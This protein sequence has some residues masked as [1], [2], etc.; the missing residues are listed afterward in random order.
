LTY[1]L[2]K[3]SEPNFLNFENIVVSA[4]SNT[5]TENNPDRSEK[6]RVT[7]HAAEDFLDLDVA[8]AALQV[9]GDDQR[10]HLRR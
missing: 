8:A 3:I 6:K 2:F 1:I 7:L 10:W 5:N 9:H 4:P